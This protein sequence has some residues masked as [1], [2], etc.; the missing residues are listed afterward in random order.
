[1]LP[2][3]SSDQPPN[4]R[5]GEL[6]GS[7]ARY[8][9]DRIVVKLRP[10]PEDSARSVDDVVSS[11]IEALPQGR[12]LRPPGATGRVVFAVAPGTDVVELARQLSQRDD[13]EY[14]EPDVVDRAAVIPTDTR[15]PDQW[16][17]TKVNAPG[18]W[19][20][21]TGSPNGVLIGI[22]DSGI[23]MGAMGGL[24]HPDLGGSRY[25]TGTDF[26]DGGDPRDLN[27]HGT[28]VTGI[29]AAQSNNAQG[30]AGMNWQTPV[31]VCRTLD[32]SG[33]GSAADFASA[34]EE[35]VDY[36]VAHGLSAVVN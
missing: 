3:E 22:I 21:T 4:A 13:V 12:T 28:H 15:F 9:T 10:L 33:N 35:I 29:A 20:K 26:V 5:E 6:E 1:M 23:S 8:Y 7:P 17:P 25:I 31:Y 11:L 2:Y 16:G 14:A 19:D 24:N 30:V 18:A 36:A 32:A 34:L 27:G